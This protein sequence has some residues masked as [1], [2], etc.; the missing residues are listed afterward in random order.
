MLPQTA[1]EILEDDLPIACMY[2]RFDDKEGKKSK[3]KKKSVKEAYEPEPNG[4]IELRSQ[5]KLSVSF[6]NGA[7]AYADSKTWVNFRAYPIF[8]GGHLGPS[9]IEG[10]QVIPYGKIQFNCAMEDREGRTIAS[11]QIEIPVGKDSVG[12]FLKKVT[13]FPVAVKVVQVE[14]DQNFRPVEVLVE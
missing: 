6:N 11:Q 8:Q 13:E 9:G 10:M 4:G 3:K 14:L 1:I 12:H 7:Y 5:A 2:K